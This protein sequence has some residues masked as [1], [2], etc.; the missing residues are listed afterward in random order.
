MQADESAQALGMPVFD[1]GDFFPNQRPA[2]HAP[3]VAKLA[4]LG[5][6]RIEVRI[7]AAACEITI[8][9][10]GDVVARKKIR[11]GRIAVE[12]LVNHFEDELARLG[13]EVVFQAIESGAADERLGMI[14]QSGNEFFQPSRHGEAVVIGEG[15]EFPSRLSNAPVTRSGRAGVWLADE[16][17]FELRGPTRAIERER[18]HAAIIHYDHL[19]TSGRQGLL[20][21]GVQARFN[22][23]WSFAG[24]DDDTNS[25]WQLQKKQPLLAGGSGIAGIPCR[26]SGHRR[27]HGLQGF[28]AFGQRHRP[29][30]V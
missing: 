3:A 8:A 7:K 26:T 14:A 23:L 2:L 19:E 30:I 17:E 9:A 6:G 10:H 4:V 25:H 12:V 11:V 27:S 28:R 29:R 16:L 1:P 18:R 5:S 13:E 21:Q 22:G 15:K 20:G 24:G